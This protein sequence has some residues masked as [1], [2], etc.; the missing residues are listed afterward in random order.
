MTVSFEQSVLMKNLM[1]RRSIRRYKPDPVP[2][3]VIENLL[4]AGIWAA[5]AHNR[6]PWRFAV[7]ESQAQKESLAAA[8]GARLRR[9]L[10]ADG[11]PEAVIEVD[12]S[13]SYSRITSAPVLIALCLSLVDMDV[14][15]DQKRN[16]NEYLMA[17]QST[18]MAGQNILLA[19]HDAG[20]GACWMCA[21]LFCPDVVQESL[22]LPQDWQPQALLTIGYPAESREKTRHPLETSMLW[23]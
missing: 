2:R 1:T 11:V 9:D 7:V 6:Q 14:Y 13:R 3:E 18:A 19:T 5:S 20:L 23:R 21:P 15:S 17:V 16:H 10:D 4:T 22:D 8:M 12:A